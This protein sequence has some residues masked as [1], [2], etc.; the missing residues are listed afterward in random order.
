[1]TGARGIE[2][3]FDLNGELPRVID[4][5]AGRVRQVVI[6]LL[7]NAVKFTEK[8]QIDVRMSSSQTAPGRYS[9]EIV[10]KD[11]GIGIEP[12]KLASIFDAFDQADQGVRMGGTGLGL[13]ISRNFARLMGGD[14]TVESIIGKGSS[15]IF[16]FSAAA[17]SVV[18]AVT[19]AGP[20]PIGLE[21]GSG[22]P[23]VLI[24]DDVAM[25]REVMSELLAEIGFEARAVASGQSA[26][27]VDRFWRPDLILL[28]LHMPDMGGLETA[29]RLRAEG[30]K[31][32]IIAITASAVTETEQDALAAGADAFIRKPYREQELLGRIGELLDI[33]YIYTRTPTID[34]S[35]AP[36]PL[37]GEVNLSK[38]MQRLPAELI[39]EIREAAIAARAARIAQLADS[40]AKYSGTASVRIK[41]LAENFDYDSL[42]AATEQSNN[43]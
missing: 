11:T 1:L 12:G 2:L 41:A 37:S 9:V 43:D 14:L 22:R 13:T 24:V 39:T 36:D 5:D 20:V 25:N 19:T 28:D 31:A 35:D 16:S 40:A 8:G 10:V 21:V 17:S 7:S 30:S 27:E 42:L 26:I 32:V 15:F 23:K 6:N 33:Q 34:R 38:L 4:G 18:I 3:N 29:R